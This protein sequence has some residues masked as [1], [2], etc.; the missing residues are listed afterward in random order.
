MMEIFIVML[1]KIK[2]PIIKFFEKLKG[3]KIDFIQKSI[4]NP[5]YCG[6][7]INKLCSPIYFKK[8]IANLMQL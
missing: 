2:N 6:I 4:N 3:N 1:K 5:D 8:N 7:L